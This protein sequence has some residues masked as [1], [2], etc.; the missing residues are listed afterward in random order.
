L[1]QCA[2]NCNLRENLYWYYPFHLLRLRD[3]TR[4]VLK[5]RRSERQARHGESDD[6]GGGGGSTG[7]SGTTPAAQTYTVQIVAFDGTTTHNIPITLT[8]N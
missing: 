4:T 7:G 5:K 8:V 6:V 2:F 1:P 3:V